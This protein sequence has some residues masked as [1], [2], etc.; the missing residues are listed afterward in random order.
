M[1]I[2]FRLIGA[3][4]FDMDGTV[5]LGDRLLPGASDLIRYL[6]TKRIPYLFF[7]NN[8]SRNV[9]DYCDKLNHLG[10]EADETDVMTSGDVMIDLLKQDYPGEQVHLLGT[11][12]LELSFLQAGIR[13]SEKANVAVAGFDMTLTYA[14][15][16]RFCDRLREGAVFYATH[17]DLNCPV[18]GGFIPDLGSFLALIGA[19]TGRKPDKIAGKPYGPTVAAVSRRLGVLPNQI[20]FVGDRLYTDIAVAVNHGAKGILVLSGETSREDLPGSNIRPDAVFD[21]LA[22]LLEAAAVFQ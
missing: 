5:Y 22:A 3:Y 7:T 11:P 14:K 19:S 6:R 20:A 15:L 4:V 1:T 17:P 2:D 8:S 21:D 10:I 9:R 12:A 18:D 13:L 16:C